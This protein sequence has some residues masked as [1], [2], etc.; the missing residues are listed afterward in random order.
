MVLISRPRTNSDDERSIKRLPAKMEKV[1][2]NTIFPEP[3]VTPIIYWNRPTE[4]DDVYPDESVLKSV[5]WPMKTSVYCHQCCH[6]FDGVPVPLPD[7]F[8]PV[9][10]VYHCRGNFCS[11]QCAKA[12]NIN[13]MNSMYGKGNRNMFIAILA[14]LTWVKYRNPYKKPVAN[15]S[16][17]KTYATYSIDPAPP[18][19]NL[20]IF[21][22]RM[23]IEEYR[24]GFFGI[25]PPDEAVEGKP[26]LI[27]RNSLLLPFVQTSNETLEKTMLST[28]MSTGCAVT[29]MID[30]SNAHLHSNS[31]CDKLNK[32]KLEKIVMKRKRDTSNNNTLMSTMG[33][34]VETKKR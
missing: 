32:A 6:P 5:R 29:K 8:D 30:T 1:D 2:G 21:G 13:D 10:K 24:K 28:P 15:S 3:P 22:G 27:S 25:V 12:Y 31:F 20:N 4:W 33:V 7:T 11:W 17:L 19:Q 14:H 26:F 18:R 16:T 23:T 34:I 9:R